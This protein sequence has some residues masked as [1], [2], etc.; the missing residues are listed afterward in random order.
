MNITNNYIKNLHSYNIL[1]S[2]SKKQGLCQALSVKK[3]IKI[4]H[5]GQI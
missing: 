5:K 2:F 3:Y 4:C 1:I